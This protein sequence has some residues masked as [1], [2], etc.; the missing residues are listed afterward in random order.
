MLLNA[1]KRY[2]IYC[3]YPVLTT[4][5][6]NI[7]NH[8]KLAIICS[9]GICVASSV[10]TITAMALDRYL[11]ITRPFGFFSRCFN[12]KMAL[13]VIACLWFFALLLFIPVLTVLELQTEIIPLPAENMTNITI[14]F[15]KEQWDANYLIPQH[16]FGIVC[17][18]TMFALPGKFCY[19]KIYI[20]IIL[21]HT[22]VGKPVV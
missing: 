14:E 8:L 10:F 1:Q 18:T 4:D 15:C 19:R 12:K 17:F 6:F 21:I 2:A 20:Y 16:V 13:F 22:Y 11:A 9:S 3:S 7:T 5:S